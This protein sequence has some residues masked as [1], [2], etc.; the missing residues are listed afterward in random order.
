M[1]N[2]ND[3][4]EQDQLDD[5][6]SCLAGSGFLPDEFEVKQQRANQTAGTVY[7]PQAGTVTVRCKTTGIERIYKLASGNSWPADFSNELHGGLFGKKA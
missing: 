4:L 1:T 3:F 7:D 6:H 2:A 5:F